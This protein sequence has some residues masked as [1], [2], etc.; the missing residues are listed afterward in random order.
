MREPLPAHR[1]ARIPAQIGRYL[2]ILERVG[3][4]DVEVTATVLAGAGPIAFPEAGPY[5][6]AHEDTG[7]DFLRRLADMVKTAT[8]DGDRYDP[9]VTLDIPALANDV[10]RDMEDLTR[11]AAGEL[12][13]PAD[14]VTSVVTGLE[15]LLAVAAGP[16]QDPAPAVPTLRETRLADAAALVTHLLTEQTAEAIA[17]FVGVSV[18][19]V[20]AWAAGQQIPRTANRTRLNILNQPTVKGCGCVN[21]WIVTAVRHLDGDRTQTIAEPCTCNPTG[22]RPK[23]TPRGCG[24]CPIWARYDHE[25]NPPQAA[26]ALR[27]GR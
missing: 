5:A 24:H 25:T 13:I 9:A 17:D 20:T 21:G 16:A 4:P 19:T 6:F 14:A 18:R 12:V 1:G 10:V 3:M 2:L 26:A 22:P 8:W 27:A 23:L 7:R 15:D 11:I